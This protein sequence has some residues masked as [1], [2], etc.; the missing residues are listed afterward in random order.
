MKLN[1]KDYHMTQI[2]YFG[3]LIPVPNH[4]WVVTFNGG[5][6][7]WTSIH[8]SLKTGTWVLD[9]DSDCINVCDFDVPADFD[10]TKSLQEVV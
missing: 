8:P 2:E 7:Y 6:V 3:N 9:Y 1:I 4:G 5:V 10:W